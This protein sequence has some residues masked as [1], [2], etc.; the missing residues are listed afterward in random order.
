MI[1]IFYFHVAAT[2]LVAI[3]VPLSVKT[4]T[5]T[6]NDRNP[7]TSMTVPATTQTEAQPTTF[8]RASS[9][10]GNT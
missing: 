9:R 5:P 10:I 8:K 4:T 6:A 3:A 7:A 1:H 2:V